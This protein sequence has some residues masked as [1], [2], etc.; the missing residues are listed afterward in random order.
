MVPCYQYE[1]T[2]N[3][4]IIIIKL[5]TMMLF[6]MIIIVVIIIAIMITMTKMILIIAA[7]IVVN[8]SFQPDDFSTGSTTVW[9]YS[10]AQFIIENNSHKF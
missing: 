2:R 4:N 9:D 10:Q 7:V 3:V 8:N 1:Q 6:M 5:M